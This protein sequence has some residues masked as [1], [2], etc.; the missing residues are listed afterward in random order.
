MSKSRG[1]FHLVLRTV[2]CIFFACALLSVLE[3]A[4]DAWFHQPLA[5]FLVRRFADV[6]LMAVGA[7]GGLLAGQRLGA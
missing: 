2:V 7:V 3:A 5:E 6:M 4:I 1:D